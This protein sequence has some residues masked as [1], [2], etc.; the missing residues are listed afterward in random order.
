MSFWKKI[1]GGEQK[2]STSSKEDTSSSEQDM[3]LIDPRSL[4]HAIMIVDHS[5][6]ISN[7]R[8]MSDTVNTIWTQLNPVMAKYCAD[9]NIRIPC[10]YVEAQRIDPKTGEVD[11]QHLFGAHLQQMNIPSEHSVFVQFATIQVA[12]SHRAIS[13]E[14]V[15]RTDK[16]RCVISEKPMVPSKTK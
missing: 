11:I 6:A 15:F 2:A 16:Q 8:N 14:T 7:V 13:M 12:G 4:T 3:T 5:Q 1:F 9:K 10:Y